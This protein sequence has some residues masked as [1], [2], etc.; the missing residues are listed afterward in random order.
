[1]IRTRNKGYNRILLLLLMLLVIGVVGCGENTNESEEKKIET[2]FVMHEPGTYDSE[3][4]SAVIVSIDKSKNTITFYNRTVEKNYTLSFDGTSKM[5]DKYGSSIVVDQLYPGDVVDL[6]FV[7]SKKLLNSLSK[8]SNVWV[9]EDVS[10]FDID[11]LSGRI[12]INGGDYKFNDK[13]KVFSED[14]VAQLIDIND[15]DRLSISGNE[16]T[17]YTIVIE[18]GHGYLRLKGQEYFEGGW[19]EV[20]NSKIIK[21][22]SEDMLLAVPV[23]N[24]DVKLSNGD[25]EG[26]RTVSIKK[27]EETVLDVSD[28]VTIEEDKESTLVLVVD[29]AGA[30]V[31]L[32]GKEVDITKPINI[33]Y[34]I[35]QL[36]AKAEGYKT[37]TQYIKVGQENATLEITMEPTKNQTEIDSHSAQVSP[38]PAAEVTTFVTQ[39]VEAG[40]A[41]N[42]KVTIDS[43][44]D[45]EIYL[46][47]VYVGKTPVSFIKTEGTKVITLRKE[48]YITRSYTITLDGSQHDETLSFSSLDKE[49]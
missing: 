17:I 39:V 28:M 14:G 24:Y 21:T 16:H 2:G 26:T 45:T 1:M 30:M 33:E 22:V 48:G 5:Y 46:D 13:L 31:Y 35:H 10:D 42:Y 40:K 23:G 34:G 18:Q 19:I 7:K 49:E 41:N 9:Y 44:E 4:T 36:I 29:P 25:Y 8:S 20:G 47:G 11:A 32:D 6:N 12:K 37:L 43:P 27:N 38:S 3:D 15:C